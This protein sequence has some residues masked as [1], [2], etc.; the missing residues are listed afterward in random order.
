MSELLKKPYQISIWEDQLVDSENGSYYEENKIA[1]IGSDTMTSLNK[2][3]SPVLKESVNGEQ[4]LSFSLKYKYFDDFLGDYVVN[5]FASYLI[6]ERK[7]KLYYKDKWYEFIIKERE[8]DS[9]EYTYSYVCTDAFVQELAKNGYGITFNT[10]SNNNQGTITELAEKTLENTDWYV[11]K[12]NSDLLQQKV[13]E[14]LYDCTITGTFEVLNIDTGEIITVGNNEV[15]DENKEHIYIFYS[16]IINEEKEYVQFLRAADQQ[17]WTY[18]DNDAIFG[19]NYRI[20]SPVT[21]NNDSIVYSSAVITIGQIL[22]EHQGYRLVYNKSTTYEPIMGRVVDLY[23]TRYHNTTQ[24]IYHY[25]DNEYTTTSLL[26]NY[27]SNGSNFNAS[28]ASVSGWSNDIYTTEA[29]QPA[30]GL[31]TYPQLVPTT[32]MMEI[33]RLK[34]LVG[35]LEAYYPA[36]TNKY[37][38]AFYNSG[39]TDNANFLQNIAKGQKF[40]LRIRYNY[41][42]EK[43]GDLQKPQTPT[44][45]ALVAKYNIVEH[46]LSSGKTLPVKKIDSKNVYLDFTENF[47][48][49][50]TIIRGGALNEDKTSY[51]LN[52]VIQTPSRKKVYEDNSIQYI[53]NIETGEYEQKTADN[54]TNYYYTV[55]TVTKPISKD[56]LTDKVSRI[57]LFLYN[58]SNTS[59][60][61]YIEDIELTKYFEDADGS[62][63]F[64]GNTPEAKIINTDYY[65]LKPEDGMKAEEVNLFTSLED[66]ANELY[67]DASDIKPIRNE[68]CEKILSINEEKSN[69]FNIL[70]SLCE[71]FE[72]WLDINV[73][74]EEDGHIKL[75]KNNRPIKTIRFKEY[76]GKNNFAGF[77]YG[78][79]LSSISRSIDSTEFV[80]K[81]MVGQ[82]ASDYTNSGT[83]SITEAPSN[84]SSESYILNFDYYLNQGLI[85]NKDEFK[86]DVNEFNLEIKEIND[87][88]KKLNDE[89]LEISSAYGKAKSNLNVYSE[90]YI[91]ASEKTSEALNDFEQL[92][93]YTYSDYVQSHP[94]DAEIVK[95][96]TLQ[97]SLKDIYAN[98]IETNNYKDLS[99]NAEVEYN[100]LKLKYKGAQSYGLTTITTNGD[101]ELLPTTKIILSDY[102]D[103]FDCILRADSLST[104]WSATYND[105]DFIENNIYD[106]IVINKIPDFYILQY[107][108]RGI[109]HTIEDFPAIIQIYDKDNNEGMIKKFQI[110][111]TEEYSSSHIS[112]KQKITD[113]E[114]RKKELEKAFYSK[115]SR[116][117]LEGTWESNNYVDPELYYLDAV[118][119][120]NANAQPKVSYT[121]NIVEISQIEGYENYDFEI[122]DKTY[123]E[124]TEF[125]GWNSKTGSPI[126]EEVVISEVEW[127]LDE[128]ETNIIT[129]QN[130]KTQFADLFQRISATVQSVQYNQASYARAANIFDVNGNIDSTLLVGSLNN[131]ADASFDL[132]A[133]G[134]LRV[135]DEGLL[136]RNLTEPGNLLI[137][138]NRGI[139]RTVDGGRTWLN[140]ISA[141]GV[142]T[143]ALTAGTVNTQNILILD[144]DNPSFRWDK[145]GL[146]AYGYGDNGIDLKTYVRYDKYG[147]YG[148]QNDEDY[149]A[150]SLEDIKDKANFGLTWDGF[151]IK[152]KY[153]DGY[154]S[155]SS[156]DDIQVVENDVERIKIGAIELR[157][158][159]RTP[160]RYGMKISNSEGES[161]LETD[162]NGNITMIGTITAAAGQIGGFTIG[163]H[164]LYNGEFG[165][166]NS[167]FLSTGYE[168]TIPIAGFEDRNTWAIGVGDNFGVDTHGNLYATNANISGVINATDGNFTGRVNAK[169][170][171]FLD[172]IKVGTGDKYIVLYGRH[173]NSNS[174]IASSEYIDNSSMGWAINGTGDA[175]FNNVSV[176]G[177]IRTAVFEYS[178]IEAVGGAFLFRPSSSIKKAVVSGNDLILTMEKPNLFQENEW[179]KLSNVNTES[180]DVND[181]LNDGGLTH[182]YRVKSANG[183]EIILADAALGFIPDTEATYGEWGE[184]T[185]SETGAREYTS[186]I[187]EPSYTDE[188]L[189]E[190]PDLEYIP[191]YV[192]LKD[193]YNHFIQIDAPRYDVFFNGRGYIMGLNIDLDKQE[194]GTTE[195]HYNE[196]E[197]TSSTLERNVSGTYIVHR[198]IGNL[199]ILSTELEN[200]TED[201][202]IADI[203]YPNGQRYSRIYSRMTGE[204]EFVLQACDMNGSVDDLVGGSLIS[205]GYYDEAYRPF[206]VPNW[207]SPKGLNLYELVNG[208]YVLTNDYTPIDGK[209]YYKEQYENGIHNYG[210]G[211]NSSDNYVNLPERAISLFESKIHPEQSVKVSYDFKGILGTLPPLGSNIVNQNIYS[212][213]MAGTQGIF[214]NNMYIGDQSHYIAFY[215]NNTNNQKKLRNAGADIVFTYDD[216]QG[217]TS[218]KTLDDRIEEIEAGTGEDAAILT[219]DSSEGNIFR[220]NQGSTDLTVTIFYGASVIINKAQLTTAFGIGAYL[221][222]EYKDNANS[223][224][225]LL[226][227]DPRIDDDGFTIHLSAANVYNKANFRCKLVV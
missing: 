54:F 83:L 90:N 119:V 189:E 43:H 149:V 109:V 222:W 192:D 58:T 208:S 183:K 219:I 188:E 36:Y 60:W 166:D 56:L 74:H 40:L 7:V 65:Y 51:I 38:N 73:E 2:V 52:G 39:F 204:R 41:A 5:P 134:T 20:T 128:P 161:V 141:E 59:Q 185:E 17:E 177:A 182:V 6:N 14:P 216:G 201:F 180:N 196:I 30:L 169:G 45:R 28:N 136:I 104:H 160:A 15:E 195:I 155:I 214:T 173:I 88:L 200:T 84:L 49:A 95:N 67:I 3:Y 121:I 210:I 44:I 191:S 85:K 89:Y 53:W 225:T 135:T 27:I 193:N 33:N 26:Q 145:S 97:R 172:E 24:D 125:F 213:N 194:D 76:T 9:E 132:T 34:E 99:E 181:I 167:I 186:V 122:G 11:D 205:F 190:N 16:Y 79:N 206:I 92:T 123:V 12:E 10:E 151:F 114:D 212:N 143:E 98:T 68:R 164:E 70:Q 42:N 147:I 133:G 106:Y 199:Y 103:D 57:G 66:L 46:T 63:L 1:V 148:I 154:V 80:T 163:E 116:F 220:D 153:R 203:T 69:C 8:E 110:I 150:S 81:L 165:E 146:N 137:I 72:C 126:R 202:I 157:P 87:E 4:T 152:N 50:N 118:Q 142:N 113:L 175:I 207:S 115:Y 138:K 215:T 156:T 105:K 187:F 209:T 144:G 223:W 168:S 130:Y 21:Y 217:G 22:L 159:G 48:E 221:E 64:I 94:N 47:Y 158:D 171:T 174:L 162:D 218:E 29:N 71:T 78:I 102:L 211:I 96:E 108:Y 197:I 18:D 112:L 91:A 62:P 111:P 23:Q 100:E 31:T 19:T 131:I 178:E 61:I 140:L 227:S 25:I 139:E 124:D 93:G 170:G 179:V 55:G 75:N 184:V 101:T 226:S 13:S 120:S 82:P 32:P 77:R 35:Y 224:V 127:H 107:T 198:Y 176:R 117:I 129:V 37:T 86:E